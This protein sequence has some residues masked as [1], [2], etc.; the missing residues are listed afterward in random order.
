MFA[1]SAAAELS[2]T[3][4]ASTSRVSKPHSGARA[5]TGSRRNWPRHGHVRCALVAL[6]RRAIHPPIPGIEL[7]GLPTGPPWQPVR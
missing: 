6:Q 7:P 4:P 1:V 5:G 2:P 3:G